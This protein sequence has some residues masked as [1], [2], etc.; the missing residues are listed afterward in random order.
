MAAIEDVKRIGASIADNPRPNIAE[1]ENV[2]GQQ[3]GGDEAR[4]AVGAE[5][6]DDQRCSGAVEYK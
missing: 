6:I 1:A 3:V 2:H 4:A 5:I